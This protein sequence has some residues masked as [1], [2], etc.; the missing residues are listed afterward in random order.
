MRFFVTLLI[1]WQTGIA[2]TATVGGSLS[3]SLYSLIWL[4]TRYC[5]V[6]SCRVYLA[7]PVSSLQPFPVLLHQQ[8]QEFRSLHHGTHGLAVSVD[9]PSFLSFQTG[10]CRVG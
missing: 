10:W 9:V 6:L 5:L 2:I 3:P 7:H 8:L 1:G 4:T